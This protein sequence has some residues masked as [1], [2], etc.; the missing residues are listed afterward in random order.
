[1]TRPPSHSRA[2]Q[3]AR[4]SFLA[5]PPFVVLLFL[6]LGFL[7]AS[8]AG[9]Q[10]LDPPEHAS[11]EEAPGASEKAPGASD[12]PMPAAVNTDLPAPPWSLSYHDGSGNGYELAQSA[13]GEGVR[14]DYSPVKPAWSSTGS[15]DGGDPVATVLAADRVVEVWRQVRGLEADSALHTEDRAKGTGAFRLVTAEGERSF[16]VERS[17]ALGSFDALLAT[18]RSAPP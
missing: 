6:A 2:A 12:P 16:I 15:Y 11:S 4:P 1:M 10:P 3:A 17:D 9:H 14:F 18:L 13:A 8:C 7:S 5:E